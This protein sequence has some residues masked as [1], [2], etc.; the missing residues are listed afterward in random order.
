MKSTMFE[1]LVLESLS[2]D[3]VVQNMDILNQHSAV[4]E[5]AKKATEL[6][7]ETIATNDVDKSNDNSQATATD[8]SSVDFSKIPRV[9]LKKLDSGYM[10]D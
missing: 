6:C 3:N 2:G 7:L 8:N 9:Y 5:E 4:I 10:S 1:I